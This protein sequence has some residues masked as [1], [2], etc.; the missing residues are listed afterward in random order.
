MRIH[1]TAR[2]RNF[3]T[4][5]N[6]LLRD[7][8]ISF[9]AAGVLVYLLSLPDGACADIRSLA[10]RRKE[11]RT[12]IGK[13]L[14]ELEDARYLRRASLQDT[15]TGYWVTVYDVYDSPY[16]AT[17]TV[18]PAAP[19]APA[20]TPAP[21]RQPAA[22]NPDAGVAGALPSGERTR[23]QEPPS[24]PP[25][26]VEVPSR[27]ARL[28][29]SL[30][31]REPRIAVGEEEAAKLGDLVEEWFAVGATEATVQEA[32]TTGLPARV[33]A[34][35]ALL[36]DRLRRKKPAPR[37]TAPVRHE[38]ADCGA[39]V[40]EGASCRR[41]AASPPPTPTGFVAAALRGGSLARNALRHGLQGLPGPR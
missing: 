11:G 26:P 36:A 40:P 34:P 39:P 16:D 17:E 27:A 8:D 41:C 1:R 9:L 28:L 23:E 21:A 13:A 24:P 31:R 15:R 2:T 33:H 19:A 37:P 7:P 6:E 10:K 5:G 20:V 14:Q 18:C 30:G 4:L 35:A 25:R 38:C 22:G 32:L 29:A 3:T 12:R